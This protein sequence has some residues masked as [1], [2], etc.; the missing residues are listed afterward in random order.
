MNTKSPGWFSLGP[1]QKC[2]KPTSYR[3]AADWKL[4]MCPP[5]SDDSLLARSTVAM[6]FHRVIDRSRHSTA[7]SPGYGGCFSTGIVLTYG[8]VI[9]YGTVAP[10]WRP[11]SM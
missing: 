8:V 4:A 9:E 1:C 2:V 7:R 5:N 11:S 10:R 6:A 3:V